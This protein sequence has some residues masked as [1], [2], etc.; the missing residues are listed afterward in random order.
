MLIVISLRHKA[1]GF[2]S[3][4]VVFSGV[5]NMYHI[6]QDDRCRRQAYLIKI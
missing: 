1:F 2:T 4:L 3:V 5:M 6:H